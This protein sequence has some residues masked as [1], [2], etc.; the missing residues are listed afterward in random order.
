MLSGMAA[1]A[2]IAKNAAL[3]IGATTGQKILSFLAFIFV[4]RF[5]GREQTG[6]FFYSVS[7]TS[8]F[9]TFADLGMTPVVIRAIAGEKEEGGRL[10]AAALRTKLFLIPVSIVAALIY[11]LSFGADRV[12]LIT[13]AIACLVMSADTIH[14]ILYGALRG[15]QNLRPEAIGMF[16]GQALTAFLSVGAAWW[17]FGPIG[18]AAALLVGS[19]WNVV[20]STMQMKQ[21]AVPWLKPRLHDMRLL[22]REAIPFALAGIAVKVYSFVDSLF[23]REF[24]GASEVGAYAVAYK[25]TYA[26]QFLPLTFTAALYPALAS[27]FARREAV[28]MRATFLGSLRVMAAISFPLSAGLS[29]LAARLIPFVYGK[30]FL[31][32][33]PVLHILPWVLIPIFLD[34][35][36]GALLNATHKAAQ[37]TGAMIAVMILNLGLNAVLVPRYSITGAAWAGVISFWGLY[38]IGVWLTR[39]Y[40]GGLRIFVWLTFRTM[41]AGGVAW[42]AWFVVGAYLPLPAAMIFGG[43]ISILMAFLMGLVTTSDVISLLK[44]VRFSSRETETVHESA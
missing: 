18:L 4:A 37:K 35:P 44:H 40:A 2:K 17:G 11:T 29:A 34:F 42:L 30:D 14:L 31:A 10:L 39:E 21:L 7:I 19:V 27:A 33:I 32:S 13:V 20:W 43:A 5:I 38:L 1:G 41:I 25:L 9:V 12:T 22:V 28:E 24:H 8:I 15:K 26:L 23:I 3:L 6:V 16:V 36:V